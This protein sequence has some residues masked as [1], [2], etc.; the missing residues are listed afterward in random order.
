MTQYCFSPSRIFLGVIQETKFFLL[1]LLFLLIGF[2][3][4]FHMLSGGDVSHHRFGNL[5]RMLPDIMMMMLG[6]M[7]DTGDFLGLA[8]PLNED[9]SV[10]G[11]YPPAP[12]P[13]PPTPLSTLLST[14]LPAARAHA[15][16]H[17]FKVRVLLLAAQPSKQGGASN[18]SLDRH[19]I[20]RPEGVS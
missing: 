18:S 4:G 13:T 19:F 14:P 12:P 9:Y 20:G 7:G 16:F 15:H 1:V 6:E 5:Q 3:L 17:V 11:K 8:D 10:F 2:G